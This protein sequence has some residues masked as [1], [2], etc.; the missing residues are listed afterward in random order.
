MFAPKY[1]KQKSLVFDLFAH[2]D[3]CKQLYKK[4]YTCFSNIDCYG[5]SDYHEILDK[6]KKECKDYRKYV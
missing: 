6:L 2:N 4:F 5:S 3:N 1:E